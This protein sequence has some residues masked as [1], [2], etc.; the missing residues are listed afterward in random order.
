MLKKNL[1]LGEVPGQYLRTI[2]TWESLLHNIYILFLLLTDIIQEFSQ[3]FY[4]FNKLIIS[5]MG[6]LS[7]K[8]KI[9]M[10]VW[11]SWNSQLFLSLLFL[12]KDWVNI[13][14]T[15]QNSHSN[16]NR[17]GLSG[18][19][20]VNVVR[21]HGIWWLQERMIRSWGLVSDLVSTL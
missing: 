8:P 18:N 13:L 20:V 1:L 6:F 15:R 12:L 9:D 11:S 19:S 7:R 4:Y 3:V 17:A 2:L 21:G 5:I 14:G 16:R 10:L